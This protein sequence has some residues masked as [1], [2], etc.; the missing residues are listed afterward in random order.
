[1]DLMKQDNILIQNSIEKLK[2]GSSTNF[3]DARELN[4]VIP[5]LKKNRIN[6]NI[7]YP[8]EEATYGIIYTY[9]FPHINLLKINTA[10]ILKHQ[11]IMGSLYSLNINKNLFG[12]IIISDSYY[13][14]VMEQISN[15]IIQN[16]TSIANH[17]VSLEKV[18]IGII[19]N[20]VPNYELLTL[21]VNSNRID[22]VIAKIIN[23]SRNDIIELIKKKK[24]ILN[25]DVLSKNDYFLKENDIFSIHRYGKYKFLGING[26][27]KKDKYIVEIKKY[28]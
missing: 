28:V 6:Y 10:Y 7:F 20:Y 12:D 23:K 14:L 2:R 5:Y 13:I 25:Y 1:M 3:L 16:L 19:K 8:Y 15:Y 18:N 21:N 26:K 24:V 11:D 22:L 27:T 17:S 9:S 4:L